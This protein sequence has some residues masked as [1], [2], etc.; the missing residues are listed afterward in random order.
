[1]ERKFQ[2]MNLKKDIKVI[3]GIRQEYITK[4]RRKIR[5]FS[6][7]AC[8]FFTTQFFLGYH[9]IYNIEWL[10]W[11]LVEPLTYT[12]S[13]GMFIAGML[14]ILRSQQK[15]KS[16]EYGDIEQYWTEEK[17]RSIYMKKGTMSLVETRYK[18]L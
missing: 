11:D 10:G 17:L 13:Q 7:V 4:Q 12:I 8:G 2:I 6:G 18:F 5:L 15:L 14:A 1:M 9:L 16:S 3:E